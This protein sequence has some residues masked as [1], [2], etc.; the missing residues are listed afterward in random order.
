MP[1]LE[2]VQSLQVALQALVPGDSDVAVV[3]QAAV[4][5]VLAGFRSTAH[6]GGITVE[7]LTVITRSP[8]ERSLLAMTLPAIAAAFTRKRREQ[9]AAVAA[10]KMPRVQATTGGSSSSAGPL[11]AQPNATNPGGA[12]SAT[13]LAANVH[14]LDVDKLHLAVNRAFSAVGFS[15][16]SARL[17]KWPRR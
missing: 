14:K 16:H 3:R 11:V 2:A 6:L 15:H 1:F 8:A 9:V 10:V 17:S 4:A 12:Q 7:E 13:V 5:C